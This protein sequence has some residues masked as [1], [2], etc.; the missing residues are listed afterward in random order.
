M[1][2]FKFYLF[3]ALAAVLVACKGGSMTPVSETIQGPL[4]EYFEVVSRD[5][6][7]QKGRVSIEFKRVKDGF[8]D[9]WVEGMEV[10]YSGGTITPSFTVEF[11]DGDGNVLSKDETDIVF[12]EDELVSLAALGVG[13]SATITF[14]CTDGAEQF[15]VVSGFKVNPVSEYTSVTSDTSSEDSGE[16]TSASASADTEETADA[17]AEDWDALL[18]SYDSYVSQ[19]ISY[20][21]KAASGD[22][23]ALTEY[24][25]FMEKAQDFSEKLQKAKGIMSASQWER[26]IKI[27]NKMTQAAVNM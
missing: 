8:P 23:T 9:P 27:T 14:D 19:Y 3:V 21:K 17:S 1:K 24:P 11:Q 2:V 4:S 16:E 12:D 6:K 5:Y 20:A 7:A 18:D 15:K 13:E 25:S 22:I 26:Y 10:G